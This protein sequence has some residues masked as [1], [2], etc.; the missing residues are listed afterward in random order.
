M[1]R[2]VI[3]GLLI[4]S[5]I[6]VNPLPFGLGNINTA[7]SDIFSSSIIIYSSTSIYSY[8]FYVLLLVAMIY[9]FKDNVLNDQVFN[10]FIISYIITLMLMSSSS[11]IKLL[12]G[13]KGFSTVL[14]IAS[15]IFYFIVV[16]TFIMLILDC[17]V[18]L[19]YK[20]PIIISTIIMFCLTTITWIGILNNFSPFIKFISILSLFSIIIMKIFFILEI[21]NLSLNNDN[22]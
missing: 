13:S 14:T 10:T 19:S 15:F 7:L 21:I 1:K 12:D 4:L 8:L 9:F 2:Y 20:N 11:L 17:F 5:V 3:M 22:I 16:T 18:D 6:Y